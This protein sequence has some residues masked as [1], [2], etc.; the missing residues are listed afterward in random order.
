MEKGSFIGSLCAIIMILVS[1]VWA[2]GHLRGFIDTPAAIII[3]GGMLFGAMVAFPIEEVKKIPILFQKVF[4]NRVQPFHG[5]I[6]TIVNLAET[7]RKEGV[8]A[9]EGRMEEIQDDFL[10]LGLRMVVDG[11]NHETVESVMEM[12]M[13]AVNSRHKAGKMVISQMGKTAP[14]FGLVATLMGLVLMLADMDPET[15]GEHM[16]VAILGTFYGA[17]GAN[18]FLLPFGEKLAYYNRKELEGMELTIQGVLGILK[19]DNPRLIRMK[20]ST[21]LTAKE[22]QPEAESTTPAE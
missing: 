6:D 3:V 11:M 18:L 10:K 4:F 14:V 9:L 7:A 1:I 13:N 12:Q 20:L 17:V 15:I 8:I 5:Q 2:G 21:Y 19:G 16:S 22:I